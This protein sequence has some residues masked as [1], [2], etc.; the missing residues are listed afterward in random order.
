MAFREAA[1]AADLWD[2]EMIGVV[3]DGTPVV[4]VNLDGVYHAY[5]DR[6]A[7]QLARLSQGFLDGR[8]LTCAAHF[9]Q[10]DA[11]T[12]CGVNPVDT[13]LRA[14]PVKVEGGAILVDTA[15]GALP[16]ASGGGDVG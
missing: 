10:Y 2:G 14:F 6:C 15:P 5:E 11:C 4:L 7:H 12:G 16:G 13:R 3:L 1:R 9:W 8:V